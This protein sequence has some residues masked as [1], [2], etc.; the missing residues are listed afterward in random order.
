M[1]LRVCPVLR[2][3]GTDAGPL[4]AVPGMVTRPDASQGIP[5]GLCLRGGILPRRCDV[6]LRRVACIWRDARDPR[7]ARG[8]ALLPVPGALSCDGRLGDRALRGQSRLASGLRS[9]RIHAGRV[10]SRLDLHGFPVAER[11][12]VAGAFQSPRRVRTA[13]RHLRNLTCRCV[14]V[15]A[16]GDRPAKGVEGPHTLGDGGHDR[17]RLWNRRMAPVA[18]LDAARRAFNLDSTPPGKHSRRAQVEGR[19]AQEDARGLSQHDR[20]GHG[21]GRGPPRDGAARPLRSTAG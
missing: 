13:A 19:D 4:R 2:L 8:V 10:S 17:C 21:E 15:V 11:R 5:F 14:D 3:A 12:D 16:R 6:D 9:R 7:G 18:R 1:R 20:R